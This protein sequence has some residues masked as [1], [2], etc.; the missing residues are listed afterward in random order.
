MKRIVIFVILLVLCVL[1]ALWSPWTKI[2]IQ[3]IFGIKQSENI[4]GLQVYSLS[5]KL[6]IYLDNEKIGTVNEGNDPYIKDDVTPGEHLI[7]LKKETS[8]VGA[9]WDL[10]K[11]IDF[12]K[13]TVVVASYNLG[14]EE[15]F[16]E[17]HIIYA[18]AGTGENNNETTLNVLSN[19][20]D[21]TL[22]IDSDSDIKISGNSV[23]ANLKL[24]SQHTIII[25]KKGYDD[26]EFT[27]LPSEQSDRDKLL[28]LNLNIDAALMLQPVQ[29][30]TK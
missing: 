7:T 22:K 21:A 18:S 23:S 15:E 3:S 12:Y 4:S 5:G 28:G 13:G 27:I 11:L 25:S 24:D 29:I 30:Q 19:V 1:L 26:L 8:V 20:Q 9:Y 14:P 17:G 2:D 10:N 6:D 16:S